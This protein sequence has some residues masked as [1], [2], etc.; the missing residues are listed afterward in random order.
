[1]AADD[2]PPPEELELELEMP[3][4]DWNRIDC[5]CV[6][7]RALTD[8]GTGRAQRATLPALEATRFENIVKEM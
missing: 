2:A 3:S 4:V 5:A 7:T 1:M 8:R 6:R